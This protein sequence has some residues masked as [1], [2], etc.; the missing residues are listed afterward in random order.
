MCSNSLSYTSGLEEFIYF[1]VLGVSL[2][3]KQVS[4]HADG[5]GVKI[6]DVYRRV[7]LASARSEEILILDFQYCAVLV[8]LAEFYGNLC[9]VLQAFGE[10]GIFG[11][12]VV[13]LLVWICVSNL[14]FVKLVNRTVV[15]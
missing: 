5:L 8:F 10:K 3:E 6:W 4:N 1:S 14:F 12:V 2:E 7:L 9:V 11:G 15:F 13:Q